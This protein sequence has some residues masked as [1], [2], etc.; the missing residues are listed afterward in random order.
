MNIKVHRGIDQVGGCITE[1][2]TETSRV[3]ID[4]GQNLPGCGEPTT[5]EQDKELVESILSQNKKAH[6]AVVYSHAH[7][8]HI[9]LF[10]YIPDS[11][12][13]YIGEGA[14]EILLAK[15]DLI[16]KGYELSMEQAKASGD[17][18]KLKHCLANLS[19]NE[20]QQSILKKFCTW[21]RAVQPETK[22]LTKLEL[23]LM[24][25]RSAKPDSF[26][27]GAISITPFFCSHSIYDPYM[28]LIEADGKR[29]WHT[30]D[31]RSHG[32]LGKGLFPTL[33]HYAKDIDVLITE[34]TMLSRDDDCIHENVVSSKMK[35]VMEAF[36]YVFVLASSTDIERLS[37]IKQASLKAHKSLYV[38]GGLTHKAMNIFTRREGCYA[39]GLFKFSNH[40]YYKEEKHLESMKKNGFVMVVGVGNL[41][42]AQAICQQ[43]SEDETLLIYSSW[44]GYYK[45]LEQVKL[46]GRYKKFRESF[47]NVVDIHTSG[48]AD[49]QTIKKVI[50]TV[51]PKEVIII[52][53][54]ADATL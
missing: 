50:E 41:A 46:D 34:G 33:K 51:Q 31:Y 49:R 36:K 35:G 27:V 16:H 21:K 37:A 18:E 48:H 5:P 30:G 23:L 24:R 4:F 25:K 40:L 29:I 44:D 39:H 38:C 3:F 42:K 47:Q 11:I 28:F 19:L 1:V 32:F 43:L 17:E 52:H 53:K 22:T 54:E 9:G 14:K 8:D 6:E 2:W 7:Q 15:Y 45:D 12:P 20:K 13:Q 10:H 26:S